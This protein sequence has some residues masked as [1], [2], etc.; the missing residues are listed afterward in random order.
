MKNS[1]KFS[2]AAILILMTLLSGCMYPGERW[3]HG[4]GS[5]DRGGDHGGDHGGDR[6]DYR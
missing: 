1:F 2:V 6:G 5:H 4:G 3:E